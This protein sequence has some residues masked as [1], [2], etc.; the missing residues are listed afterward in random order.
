MRVESGVALFWRQFRALLKKNALLAW[1]NKKVT[2][3]FLLCPFVA[4]LLAFVLEK[5]DQ[6]SA[7]LSSAGRK[8]IRDPKSLMFPPI[9]RCE[10]KF[11]I[12]EPCYDF[13]WSGNS[14]ATI[15]EIVAR[16]MASNPGRPIPSSKVKSFGTEEE[17]DEWLFKDPLRCPG[18]LHFRQ[19]N[20]TFITYGIQTNSTAAKW[21]DRYEDP[22]FKFQIPLQIAAE[23]EIARFLLGD[24]NFSWTVGFKEYP[25]PKLPINHPQ[26]SD[27]LLVPVF[28]GTILQFG[29]TFQLHSVVTEKELK[30]RQA[31]NIIGLYDSA[32]W[33]SWLAW[34][35]TMTTMSSVLTVLSGMMFQFAFFLHNNFVLLFLVFFLFQLDML[36][37]AFVLTPFLKKAS[38]ALTVGFLVY[39]FSIILQI[40]LGLT[41]KIGVSRFILKLLPPSVLTYALEVLTAATVTDQDPGIS[42][43]GRTKCPPALE[44]CKMTVNGT[45]IWFTVAFFLWLML[46]LYLDNI[47]PGPNGVGKP[48]FYFLNPR[49]WTGKEG[50]W[51][52]GGSSVLRMEHSAPDDDD[53]LEEENRVKQQMNLGALDP[54]VAV[55]IRGLIKIY[56][57]KRKICGCKLRAT[58]PFHAIRDLWV[59]CNTDQLFCLLGP[60]G[61]GKTTT[62]GCLT[63]ITSVTGGDALIYGNS[64]RSSVGMSNIRKIIGVCPQFDIL[65]KQ[66]SGEEH[67]KL[68]ANIKGL[69]PYSIRTTV[70]KSLAEVGLTSSSKVRAGSYS[71]GMRRRLSFA[72]ALLG[73]PKLVILDEP[74]TGMDPISRR[75]VWDIIENAKRG[76]AIVLTTH[77]MEE[78]DVLGDRIGIMAKG[79]LRCIGTSIRLKSKFGT[80]F[81]VNVNFNGNNHRGGTTYQEATKNFFKHHLDVVPKEENEAFLTYVIPRDK[82]G[83][84][85][86]FFTELQNREREFCI[87][88][89]QLGL[90]TLEEV[91]LNIANQAELESAAAEGKTTTLTLSAGTTVQ[92]PVG[93][94]FV[95]VPG[96]ETAANPRG[97]MV[98]V[99]WGHDDSGSL[100]I[101]GHSDEMPVPPNVELNN[102]ADVPWSRSLVT[103]GEVRGIVNDPQHIHDTN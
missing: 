2:S 49:Y 79:R 5:A 54:N 62:I 88:D 101:S 47:I 14:S 86:I 61:A 91:F 38:N 51:F 39:L 97:T 71:G 87:T 73:D 57:G 89:I 42:W 15:R 68:F 30:L 13:A 16:L 44:E 100:C 65:W 46:A 64:I 98:E 9:P 10:D 28:V 93:T 23:R 78:A 99:Y 95:A 33:L 35:G 26:E 53:V 103:R 25:H 63:G 1:R 21:K 18:A 6:A 12:R 92:I 75:Q 50:N 59:N 90:T 77:S 27:Y 83:K 31:M 96:T 102:P 48:I 20:A 4:L 34:E 3:A 55:Q 70:Q 7:G 43:S 56:Y 74:T 36:A 52:D 84:L 8:E 29:F 24:P 32:Y 45:L 60:N 58:N 11:Y 17:T 69:P 85:K 41:D 76:R 72:I 94:R 22:T 66:L 37:V 81:V 40:G 82:E 19:Q 80:G 67:L